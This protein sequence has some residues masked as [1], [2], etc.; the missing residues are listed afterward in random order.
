[1]T[2]LR[3]KSKTQFFLQQLPKKKER[4]R[5]KKKKKKILRNTPNQRH[6]I[7]LQVKLPNTAE[8]NHRRHKQM[9]THS[10]LMDR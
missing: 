3:I 8:R 6:K 7:S 9:E 10:T 5:E 4:E 2:K 1:M